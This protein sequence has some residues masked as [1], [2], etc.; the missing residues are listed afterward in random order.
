MTTHSY[1]PS[2]EKNDSLHSQFMS[3]KNVIVY[4]CMPHIKKKMTHYN[5]KSCHPKIWLYIIVCHIKKKITHYNHI[6][7]SMAIFIKMR[8]NTHFESS[9]LLL[10]TFILMI[11]R[12]TYKST[13]KEIKGS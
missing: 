1:M 5:Y 8:Q 12:H 9:N 11:Q 4:S 6:P 3:S 7:Y 13:L 2:Q 10:G